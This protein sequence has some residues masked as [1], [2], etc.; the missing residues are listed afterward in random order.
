MIMKLEF[1]FFGEIRKV[2]SQ[3]VLQRTEIGLFRYLVDRNSCE[4]VLKGK[5]VQENSLFCKRE[6]FGTK[7]GTEAGCP[8]V[9]K[10]KPSGKKTSFAAQRVSTGIQEEKRIYE[11]WKKVQATQKHYRPLVKEHRKEIRRDKT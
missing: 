1:L 4:A 6:I 11:F 2:P 7:I 3:A 5:G 9:L 8:N 10:D